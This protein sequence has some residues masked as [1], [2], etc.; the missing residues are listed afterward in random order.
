MQRPSDKLSTNDFYMHFSDIHST[1]GDDIPEPVNS[2]ETNII[3]DLDLE[4]TQDEVHKVIKYLKTQKSPGMDG[5]VAE[6]FKS[7]ADILSPILVKIFNVVFLTWLLS[8][9]LVRRR[10]YSDS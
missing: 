8:E 5:L 6:I 9:I 3:N 10:H 2:S 7:S 1:S 4:I